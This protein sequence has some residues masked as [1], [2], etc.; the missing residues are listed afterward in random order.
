MWRC[1]FRQ[2]VYI[3]CCLVKRRLH[4]K[5]VSLHSPCCLLQV[6]PKVRD[7]LTQLSN[8]LVDFPAP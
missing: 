2:P 8:P 3:S 4:P 1:N 5:E 7:G 6:I